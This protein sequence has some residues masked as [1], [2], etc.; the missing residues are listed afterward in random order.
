MFKKLPVPVPLAIALVVSFLFFLSSLG[1][2]LIKKSSR[3]STLVAP[4]ST[5]SA[6]SGFSLGPVALPTVPP[7]DAIFNILLLG[8]GDPSHP[9]GDLAD[10]IIVV[11]LDTTRKV[12]GLV[13]VPRDTWVALPEKPD[14]P[15]TARPHKINEAYLIGKK[16][17]GEERGFEVIKQAVTLVTGLPVHHV[18][19]I[20]FSGLNQLISA[21]GGI[22]VDVTRSFDDYFYPVRGLELETCGRSGED[23]AA[24]SATLSGFQLEKHFPCRYEHLSFRAGKTTMDGQTALKFVRS[25]H[26]DTGGGDFARAERQ[27]AVLVAIKNRLLSLGALKKVPSLYD[28]Y[29]RLVKSDLSKEVV[30]EGAKLIIDPDAYEVKK[31]ILSTDNVLVS[32]KSS[33]GQYILTPKAGANTWSEVQN[34]I[35]ESLGI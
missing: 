30:V 1:F 16:A 3:S 7:A 5:Q 4:V 27:Q 28:Q 15:A 12:V 35:Q 23:I 18:I 32:G 34:L 10:S 21:L 9:G 31:V 24:L 26:A 6:E 11:H 14:D 29:S 25:R 20:D 8:H 33:S 13:S 22:E 2:Y 19:S 17:G